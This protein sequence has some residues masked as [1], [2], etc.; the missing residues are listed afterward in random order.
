MTDSTQATVCLDAE[1]HDTGL[2]RP[3]DA[4][5]RAAGFELV[6]KD[7]AYCWYFTRSK[8]VPIFA[9]LVEER[10][11]SPIGILNR[12]FMESHDEC[13]RRRLATSRE[14]RR[15]TIMHCDQ[16]QEPHED[17]H[18][19]P[20]TDPKPPR[21]LGAGGHMPMPPRHPR[22]PEQSLGHRKIISI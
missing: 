21:G 20:P 10:A 4:E 8:W 1:A 14:L 16:H 18:H 22:I 12:A 13:S 2:S 7:R 5:V 9:D 11:R 15:K 6:I 3:S 19:R 17:H